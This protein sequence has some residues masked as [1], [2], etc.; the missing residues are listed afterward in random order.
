ME[1]M[2]GHFI[3]FLKKLE[4]INL[5]LRLE[6]RLFYKA[7]TTQ[8][9]GAEAEPQSQCK[10][11]CMLAPNCSPSAGNMDHLRKQCGLSLRNGACDLPLLHQART[12]TR[13][14]TSICTRR[15]TQRTSVI[16]LFLYCLLNLFFI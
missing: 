8:A 11:P 2:L 10:R 9:W 1:L 13:A 3:I 4:V 5:A 7:P 12:D 14:C 6:D 16:Y 15:N